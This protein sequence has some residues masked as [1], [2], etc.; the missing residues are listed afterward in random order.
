MHLETLEQKHFK[1]LFR[2]TSKCEPWWGLDRNTSDRLFAKR[3][4]FVVV[5]EAGETVG[6]ITFDSYIPQLEVVIHA[7][8]LPEFHGKWLTRSIY[9]KVFD[10]VFNELECQRAVGLVYDGLTDP[11]FHPAL[12]F[13]FE[14][15]A[16]RGLRVGTEYK[17]IHWYSM[18]P[19]ERR[20]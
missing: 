14:G 11:E 13:K 12:G 4:G 1:K 10:R 20:W 8:I 17:D 6:H 3:E 15:T 2:I 9:K 19:H 18:L 7:C 5:T 16:R